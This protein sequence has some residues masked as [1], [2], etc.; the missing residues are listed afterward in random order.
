M[1][2]HIFYRVGDYAQAE[3]WFAA[4]TA[5]DEQYMRTQHV[6]VDDD[7][8]YVHNLMY[9]IANYMEEGKL[10]EATVLSAKLPGARGQL[11]DTLYPQSPRDGM[12]RLDPE[13]PVAL[14]TGDWAGV[15][16]MLEGAKPDAK[17]ENLNFLAGGL[18][19]F[20]TGMQAVEANDVATAQAASLRLDAELWRMSQK[21][22]DAPKKKLEPPATPVMVAVMPD[23]LAGPLLS[24]LSVMSL[25]LRGSIL[26]QQKQLA[27]AKVL[28]D[29]AALE[30]KKLGYREPPSFIRPVGETEGIALLH[31]KDYAG[32]HKAYEAALVERPKSGFPLF[33]MA[34][35][36]E[37]AGD[38]STAHEEYAKFV[39]A[40]RNGDPGALELAHAREYLMGQKT[41]AH[42]EG[43]AK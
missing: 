29:Q 8:N 19:E 43:V 16:K 14:R 41:V 22:K 42:V 15:L 32:A 30:E 5:V 34:Q 13:L 23:A 25:E 36:S 40:W 18:K 6:G 17:L 20:S 31:A 21:I 28:F 4:S 38:A 12:A 39:E 3:H 24:N 33:G 26:V 1:P 27:E 9:G 2:G 10:H 37:M 7:W 11:R 35:S